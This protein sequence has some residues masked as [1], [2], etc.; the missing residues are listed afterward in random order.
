MN[1]L[2]HCKD[3]ESS[4]EEAQ[5]QQEYQRVHASEWIEDR[6]DFHQWK[7][8]YAVEEGRLQNG[9][10]VRRLVRKEGGCNPSDH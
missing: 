10:T 5:I 4:I 8:I 2:T 1:V 6:T 3:I 7:M 9:N